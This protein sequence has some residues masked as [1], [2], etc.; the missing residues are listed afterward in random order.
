MYIQNFQK[1]HRFSLK[2]VDLYQK[3]LLIIFYKE[4]LE[5]V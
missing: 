5:S 2:K 4:K 3:H 1:K